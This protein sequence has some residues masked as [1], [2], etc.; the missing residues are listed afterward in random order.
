MAESNARLSQLRTENEVL[1]RDAEL[2]YAQR[3]EL[4]QKLAQ[5][6]EHC[7]KINQKL[8]TQEQRFQHELDGQTKLAAY[9]QEIAESS[10]DR[11]RLL[12]GNSCLA[13]LNPQRN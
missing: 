9:Y 11:I 10:E 12:E 8:I 3:E 13:S 1:K 6:Q 4:I 7:N 2:Y 5:S